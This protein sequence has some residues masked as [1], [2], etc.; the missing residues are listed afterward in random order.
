ML[1]QQR[2]MWDGQGRS[3]VSCGMVET[4]WNTG[5]TRGEKQHGSRY[6][7]GRERRGGSVVETHP[8]FE[9]RE[10][11]PSFSAKGVRESQGVLKR[12][13]RSWKGWRGSKR[14]NLQSQRAMGKEVSRTVGI[15]I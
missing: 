7:R 13:G 5:L 9:G 11:C 15:R 10:G 4:G 3:G 1:R 12:I 8:S 6:L 2:R 14:A